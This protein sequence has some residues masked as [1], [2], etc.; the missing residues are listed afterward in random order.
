MD[1]YQKNNAFHQ[2]R[3]CVVCSIPF[4]GYYVLF[5]LM[6]Y[7]SFSTTLCNVSDITYNYIVGK[8]EKESS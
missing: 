4:C 3:S 2:H 5:T 8:R 6:E 7:L 1:E